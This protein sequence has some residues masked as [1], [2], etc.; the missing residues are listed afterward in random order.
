MIAE[1]V[2]FKRRPSDP[3]VNENYNYHVLELGPAC[4]LAGRADWFFGAV[5]AACGFSTDPCKDQGY[6]AR[7]KGWLREVFH[8]T[9][10]E[11]SWEMGWVSLYGARRPSKF[12]EQNDPSVKIVQKT[13]RSGRGPSAGRSTWTRLPAWRSAGWC[14][15]PGA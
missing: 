8:R 12:R 1:N 5:A 6:W 9:F 15:R 10:P 2:A 3:V 4:D 13:I 14:C 11:S 7:Q